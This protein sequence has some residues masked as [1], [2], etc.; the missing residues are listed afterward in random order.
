MTSKRL[1]Y[2][3]KQ[4]V[5]KLFLYDQF[6]VCRH[7]LVK[8]SLCLTR[9]PINVVSFPGECQCII[10]DIVCDVGIHLPDRTS[11]PSRTRVSER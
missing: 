11:H 2:G 8:V 4:E 5:S 1:I 3:R 7:Q 6:M 9:G 10:C